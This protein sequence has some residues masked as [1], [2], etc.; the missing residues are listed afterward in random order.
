MCYV[1]SYVLTR[2]EEYLG[3]RPSLQCALQS[4]A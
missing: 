2:G 3:K 1:L 4:V